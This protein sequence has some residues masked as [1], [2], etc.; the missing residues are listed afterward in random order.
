MDN[1]MLISVRVISYNA[2]KTIL[3]TLESIKNQTYQNI[4]LI[5]SDDCSKDNTVNIVSSWL[6]DNS[7]RF[8]DAKLITVEKNTGICANLNRALR[9]CHGE[10]IKGIAADDILLPNCIEDFVDFVTKKPEA[11]F[12][13]SLARVYNESFDE[14]NYTKTLG[15]VSKLS[16]RSIDEQL[17]RVAFNPIIVAP[18]CFYNRKMLNDIGG[19]DERY[20]YEDHPLYIKMLEYG[21]RIYFL[22]KETVGYRI[23]TSTYN[24]SGKLFN[25]KFIPHSILFCKEKCFKY[26]SWRQKI[27]VKSM[28]AC[29]SIFDKLNINKAT[30]INQF[31][32]KKI[33]A[34]LNYFGKIR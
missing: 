18:T 6:K 27:A 21:V 33:M 7:S 4:E 12:V 17:K 29:Y 10:W 15:C 16:E 24:A 32:F 3:E 19:Y 20:A 22:N 23:H 13:T 11:K 31:I 28:W 34:F 26:Y 14:N 25:S 30:R 8:V 9:E 1:K 5:I 2:E